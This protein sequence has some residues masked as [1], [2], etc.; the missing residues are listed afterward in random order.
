MTG[1]IF[2]YTEIPLEENIH[3]AITPMDVFGNRGK[4]IYSKVAKFAKPAEPPKPAE[5]AKPAEKGK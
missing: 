1:C 3:F 4:T 5:T 2:A